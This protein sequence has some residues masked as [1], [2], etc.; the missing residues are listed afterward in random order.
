MDAIEKL[1]RDYEASIQALSSIST[2]LALVLSLYFGVVALRTQ[3][4][5]FRAWLNVNVILDRANL[6]E[7]VEPRFIVV[8]ITNKGTVPI[9]IPWS[10]FH[11]IPRFGREALLIT[12]LSF[13]AEG[14]GQYDHYAVLRQPPIEVVPGQ[15]ETLFLSNEEQHKD[16]I[17]SV[18]ERSSWFQF[19]N[20]RFARPTVYAED[21]SKCRVKMSSQFR[22][23]RNEVLHRVWAAKKAQRRHL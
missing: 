16:A 5:N 23:Q 21:G 9:R 10:F 18:V 20:F 6:P 3:R 13:V 1:L 19:Q 4:P 11:W 22:K 12:P 17:I 15:T 14:R 7:G 2:F 8:T